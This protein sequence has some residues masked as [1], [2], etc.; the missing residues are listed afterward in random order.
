VQLEGGEVGIVDN[1][2]KPDGTVEVALPLQIMNA[3]CEDVG[4]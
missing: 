1:L 4:E 3:Q 2:R